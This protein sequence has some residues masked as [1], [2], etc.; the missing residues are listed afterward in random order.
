MKHTIKVDTEK[1]KEEMI[2]STDEMDNLNFVEMIFNGKTIMINVDDLKVVAD[3]LIDA[4]Q[5]AS[6]IS[7]DL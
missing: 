6:D 1:G 5:L 7:Y 3:A 4:R 2:F